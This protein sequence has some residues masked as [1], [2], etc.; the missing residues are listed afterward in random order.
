VQ[1]NI[2]GKP[3]YNDKFISNPIRPGIYD[4]SSSPWPSDETWQWRAVDPDG[5]ACYYKVRPS[6]RTYHNDDGEELTLW[7][8]KDDD[9]SEEFSVLD[10]ESE[11]FG[12]WDATNW[13]DSLEA[14]F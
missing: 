3:T 4:F 1:F 10:S 9:C 14:R 6:I 11:L 12:N 7:D 5:Y 8:A 13:E 2:H